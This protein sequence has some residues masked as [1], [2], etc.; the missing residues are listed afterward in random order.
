MC[1]YIDKL[2]LHAGHGFKLAPVVG[3]IPT[4]LALDLPPFYDLDWIDLANIHQ[5]CEIWLCYV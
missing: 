4:E 3:K 2:S 5:S 1:M